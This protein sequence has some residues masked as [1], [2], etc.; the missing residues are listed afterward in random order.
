MFCVLCHSQLQRGEILIARHS[1]ETK[2]KTIDRLCVCVCVFLC[3]RVCVC[4]C[5]CVCVC[6]CVCS[7]VD[8]PHG[9]TVLSPFCSEKRQVVSFSAPTH[10]ELLR[11]V[12]DHIDALTVR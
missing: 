4:M 6:V 11:C 1:E 5:V 12:G 7:P 9:I 2:H 8:Y 10:D 3:E